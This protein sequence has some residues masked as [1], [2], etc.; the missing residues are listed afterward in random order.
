[1]TARNVPLPDGIC[2][3]C[4]KTME[5]IRSDQVLHADCRNAWKA[6]RKRAANAKRAG[7]TVLERKPQACDICGLPVPVKGMG[8]L[9]KRHG[10]ECDAE[11]E[12][13][14]RRARPQTPRVRDPVL[15]EGYR[16]T[17]RETRRERARRE[18]LERIEAIPLTTDQWAAYEAQVAVRQAEL[19]GL[20]VFG[21]AP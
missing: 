1:M 8:R 16:E 2:R 9:P 5:R 21:R 7:R 20:G 6:Y 11:A 17:Y 13:R 19:R 14:A 12:R 4:G 3:H 15:L 18:H 10:G